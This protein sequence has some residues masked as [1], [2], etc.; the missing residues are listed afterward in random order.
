MWSEEKSK[1]ARRCG[2]KYIFKSNCTKHV[3]FGAL[4]EA[5][6]WKAHF[7]VKMLKKLRGLEHFLKL[8]C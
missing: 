5:Q 6:M 8:R 7:Q 2:K 3:R 1:I 4:F